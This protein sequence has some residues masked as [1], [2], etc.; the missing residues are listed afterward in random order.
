LVYGI[1]GFVGYSESCPLEELGDASCF[2]A[3]I[4]KCVPDVL[5]VCGA[6]FVSLG[7]L[8]RWITDVF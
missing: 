6:I 5:V 3:E 4:C 8:I 1:V 2:L 7:F